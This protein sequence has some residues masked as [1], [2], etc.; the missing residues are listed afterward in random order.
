MRINGIDVA[1]E[2]MATKQPVAFI[3]EQV[4]FHRV[5]SGFENLDYFLQRGRFNQ[6]KLQAWLFPCR[7]RPDSGNSLAALE[8]IFTA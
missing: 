3:P 7:Q 1:K 5:L 2:L 8:A 6:V 4:N